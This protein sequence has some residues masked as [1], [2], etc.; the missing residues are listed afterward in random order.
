MFRPPDQLRWT[1]P[2][3]QQRAVTMR[4]KKKR[5]HDF[6]AYVV[7]H[8]RAFAWAEKALLRRSEGKFA[9]AK[10]AVEKVHYWM[11]RLPMLAPQPEYGGEELTLSKQR[12]PRRPRR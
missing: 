9:R 8:Q 12:R 11:H 6:D 7:A 2:V 4:D 5:C 3:R 10:T 1:A